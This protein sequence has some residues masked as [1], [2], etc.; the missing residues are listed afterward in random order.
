MSPA[1]ELLRH[2]L[3]ARRTRLTTALSAGVPA[4]AP[5]EP[6]AVDLLRRVDQALERLEVG[7]WGQ[8]LVCHGSIEH[9][10][11]LADP[12]V[13]IC[14]DCMGA[15]DRRALE[16]DLETAARIQ[17]AFLPP[18]HVRHDGWEVA[19]LWEP[20]GPV[21]GDHCDLLVPPGSASPMHVL[22]G[23]VS[24]KGVA[25]SLLQSHLRALFR[26]LAELDLPL[27]DLL[28]RVNRLFCE[29][30]T[31]NSYATLL[32][33]R[34][35]V[36]GEVELAAGGHLPPLV[37]RDGA[38]ETVAGHGLP[39]GLFSDV[40]FDA[41][42]LRLATGD[43]LLF[44]T[45]GWTEAAIPDGTEYG[46]GRAAAALAAAGD[47]PLPDLL[48]VCRADLARFLDGAPRSDDLTLMAVRRT[49]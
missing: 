32:A 29:A 3:V 33:A 27:P 13:T 48:A 8:C 19:F 10:R 41:S 37:L 38:V 1:T 25:A 24:G 16:R 49:A 7:T 46:P 12:L 44:Y 17:R 42:R 47:R 39:V 23:D 45:D 2:E 21:S 40:A 15:D 30:T 5:G 4:P 6:E 34:L 11:L 9:D 31:A 14:L 36:D 28:A 26:A 22:F 35:A 18:P 20:L 43:T